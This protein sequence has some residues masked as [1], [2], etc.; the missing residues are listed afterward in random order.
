MKFTASIAA[1]AC[2]GTVLLAQ[3]SEP[4]TRDDFAHGAS[5]V[6]AT[7]SAVYRLTLNQAVY[8][9]A[10]RVDL[11]DLRVFNAAGEVVPHAFAMPARP[12]AEA[13]FADLPLFPVSRQVAQASDDIAMRIERNKDGSIIDVRTNAPSK[14]PPT[15]VAFY[16][17]DMSRLEKPIKALDLEW[18]AADG[19]VANVQIDRSSDLKS[20]TPVMAA[21]VAKL[22]QNGH[23]LEQRRAEFA[24]ITAKYLRLT[25]IDPA[26]AAR[27]TRV[28]AEVRGAEADVVRE[29]V[30]LGATPGPVSSEYYFDARGNF[31][32]DKVRLVL[33]QANTVVTGTIL[34]RRRDSDPWEVR[35]SGLFY[36][37]VSG[38]H[39]IAQTDIDVTLKAAR[40]W[41]FRLDP[42]SA[43]L[44]AAVPQLELGWVPQQLVFVARGAGPFSVAYGSATVTPSSDNIAALIDQPAGVHN[45]GIVAGKATLGDPVILR[46]QAALDT[47]RYARDWKNWLLWAVLIA[48]VGLL[49]WFAVRLLKQLK[50]STP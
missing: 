6:T 29:W 23:V 49:G 44:G 21:P 13:T 9:G 50:A 8:Q 20:W 15:A 14:T 16:L 4:P 28:R 36:S 17:I 48:G 32:V 22:N 31:P 35:G 47:P 42:K 12:E 34:S 46:G 27:I 30:R 5:I 24:P 18:D 43:G 41:L 38:G 33:P 40:Q 39:K 3:A 45:P 10:T 19:F 37:L 25:W 7:D 11:G 1:V 2:A 26:P